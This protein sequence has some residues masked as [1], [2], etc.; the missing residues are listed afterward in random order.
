MG[1]RVYISYLACCAILLELLLCPPVIVHGRIIRN[2]RTV[3]KVGVPI[4]RSFNSAF[5]TSRCQG[6]LGVLMSGNAPR[7]S[8]RA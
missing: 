7:R 8:G 2:P 5:R 6:S 4:N 1:I 3:V